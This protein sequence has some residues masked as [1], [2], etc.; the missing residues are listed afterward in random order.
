ML[1]ALDIITL[2]LV[3][4]GAVF[5][6][7]RG[8]VTEVLSLFAWVAAVLALKFLYT[9]AAALL[10]PHVGT[11]GGAAVLAFALVFGLT[12]L[13]GKLVAGRLG[14]RTRE[15][16]LGPLDR[17]LGFGFGALKGLIGAT[18]LFLLASLAYDSVYGG[19]AVRPVWMTRSRS[20]PLLRAGGHAIVDFV[21]A[22]RALHGEGAGATG[23]TR[24][25]RDTI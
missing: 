12:F 18:L 10:A 4:G 21:A 8:F 11:A 6:G 13:F 7:L 2:L 17:L 23:S 16:I 22:R 1:T 25:R 5:G 15:S 3:G 20:Y 14:R 24:A 9:P 19:D